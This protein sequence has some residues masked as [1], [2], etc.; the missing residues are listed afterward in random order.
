MTFKNVKKP[1]VG[2]IVHVMIQTLHGK[3][4]RPAIVVRVG[5]SRVAEPDTGQV[6]LSVFLAPEDKEWMT[7]TEWH[8]SSEGSEWKSGEWR[9]PP[10]EVA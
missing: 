2:R 3:Q 6:A 1:T 10:R 7:P 5:P 9:W 8:E 4:I